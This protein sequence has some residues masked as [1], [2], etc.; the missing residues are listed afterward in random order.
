MLIF[1][2]ATIWLLQAGGADLNTTSYTGS[3]RY[4]ACP[5]PAAH[6]RIE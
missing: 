2:P 4:I 1:T 6:I 5:M 3:I